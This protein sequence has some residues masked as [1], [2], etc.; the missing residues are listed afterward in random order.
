MTGAPHAVRW[1]QA[2]AGWGIPQALVDA[3]PESPWVHDTAMF[4]VDASVPRQSVSARV[5]R[6]ALAPSGT[7][8]DVGVGGGR[9][10]LGLVPEVERIVGVDASVHMLSSFREAG[11]AA[12]VPVLGVLGQ[13]PDVAPEVEPADVVVCHHV[14]YNVADIDPFLRALTN[15][16]VR[17]V[18]V[19][20]TSVHPTSGYND[21]WLHFH[22]LRRPSEPT[23]EDAVAVAQE[24][25]VDV[26][27]ELSP[28]PSMSASA[29]DPVHAVPFIRRRLCLPADRDEEIAAWLEAHPVRNPP[30]VAT[31]WWPGA[32][33]HVPGS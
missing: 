32:A 3:A 14:L 5:A 13:W 12:G 23:W 16:A 10:S 26:Q 1:A 2:L 22:G 11:L 31:L 17:R 4:A 33:R 7:V 15:H 8:L 18:V 25:G 29:T 20:I 27:V 9:S 6:E 28:R 30:T 21:A 24:L 19:E